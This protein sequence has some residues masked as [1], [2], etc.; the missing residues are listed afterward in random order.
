ML[1]PPALPA[2]VFV[3]LFVAACG[4]LVVQHPALALEG[5]TFGGVTVAP[6][7]VREDASTAFGD[8]RVEGVVQE[9]VRS[10]FGDVYVGPPGAV[11]D[12][13]ET[14]FGDVEIR[15]PVG[16]DVETGLGDVYI[17]AP[18]AGSVDVGRGE[19]ELGPAARVAGDVR[20]GSGRI[21]GDRSAVQGDVLTGMMSDAE[22]LSQEAVLDVLPGGAGWLFGAVVFAAC[23]VL[24]AVLAPRPL[25]A[26]SRRG[27]TAPGWSA[28]VGVLSVPAVLTL[29]VVF[30]VSIIAIPAIL[31]VV[32]AYLALLFF[33]ALVAAYLIGRRIVLATGRYRSGDALAAIVGALAVSVAYLIPFVGGLVVYGLALFGTGAALLALFSRGRRAPH[34]SYE[35]YVRDRRSP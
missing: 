32:P 9:D 1:R 18:V 16:G 25:H 12:D 4:V 5:K 17:N 33:G 30:A 35:D 7:E 14:G 2:R 28:V 26:A 34:A 6:G 10:G 29:V 21:L 23:S 24:L 15:A 22:E 31:L 27:E 20:C 19:V 3:A 11:G 8:V 13:V